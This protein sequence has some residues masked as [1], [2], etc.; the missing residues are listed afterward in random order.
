MGSLHYPIELLN[1]ITITLILQLKK[2]RIRAVK[3][4]DQCNT[5]GK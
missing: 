4:I 5:A 1:I 3:Y 2:L